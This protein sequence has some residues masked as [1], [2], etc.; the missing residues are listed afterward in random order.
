MPSVE[1]FE[2]QSSEYKEY[3]LPKQIRR[4][5]SIEMASTAFWYKYV[6]LDGIAIGID[7]F[8]SSAPANKV[9]E[10]YG[11]TVEKI[12]QKIKELK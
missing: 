8:G 7:K 9:M 6:G 4:R 10:E 12:V 11:F 1:L 2:E 3:L 5:I